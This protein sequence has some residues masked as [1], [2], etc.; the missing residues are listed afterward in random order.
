LIE[1][2]EYEYKHINI[3]GKPGVANVTVRPPRGDVWQ[4]ILMTAFQSEGGLACY[5]KHCHDAEDGQGPFSI[6]YDN[7]R[8][9]AINEFCDLARQVI[10]WDG[11]A[12]AYAD[13][14][15]HRQ[16][17]ELYLTWNDYLEFTASGLGVGEIATVCGLVRVFKRGGKK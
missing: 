2:P 1:S 13:H 8:T 12:E 17:G 15:F 3:V 11:A 5:W 14:G 7:V 10:Y 9:W 6:Y 16:Y 4:V